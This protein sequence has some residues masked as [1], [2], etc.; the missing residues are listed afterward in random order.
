MRL[1]LTDTTFHHGHQALFG[2]RI[3]LQEL[4][5]ALRELD[6]LGFAAIDGFGEGSFEAALRLGQDPWEQ[7]RRLGELLPSTPILALLRGQGLVG[8]RSLADDAVEL[9]V[10]VAARHGV[11]V[12]RFLDPLNDARNLEVPIRAAQRVGGRVQAVLCHTVSPVHDLERW[13]ALARELAGLGAEELVL[14]DDAGLLA[15]AAARELVKALNEAVDLPLH[16]RAR[17]SAGLGAMTYLRAVESGAT[18]LDTAFS[19]FAWGGSL[20]AVES[21]VAALAAG[22]HDPGLDLERLVDLGARLEEVRRRHLEHLSPGADRVD[23][24]VIGHGLP[25]P[26]LREIRE[27]LDRHDAGSRLAE[28]LEEVPRVREEL[29]YPPLLP[30]FGEMIAAQAVFN[31]LSGDRYLTVTQ[32]LKDYLQGLYGRPP[33]TVDTA[34]RRLVLGHDEPITVRPADLLDPQVEAARAQLERRGLPTSDED[35]LTHLLFPALAEDLFRARTSSPPPTAAEPE[36]EA[37]AT[38][39]ATEAGME[40]ALE[41]EA[42]AAPIPSAAPPVTSAEFEVEVEGEVF[43]VRVAGAGLTVAPVAAPAASAPPASPTPR[44][45]RDGT[46]KAPMQGL[47]VK[48][49]VSVGDEVRLGDVVAVLEAMKMQNDIVATQPGKV[50]DIFV[51]EGDVVSPDQALVAIG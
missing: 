40:A 25:A 35:L 15:P 16:V 4:E 29:G 44:P 14:D 49:P 19:A 12:F 17:C 39:A 45:P 34:V 33:G 43:R 47:I 18:G 21:V 32:E 46:I 20:P 6:E 41:A 11:R 3:P 37:A 28:V 9:F 2:S 36:E 22:E 38:E 31:V 8:H 7:L 48:I 5:P 51:K 27:H 10:E 50:L 23:P 1:R 13:R 24:E 42:P 26:M 30:P